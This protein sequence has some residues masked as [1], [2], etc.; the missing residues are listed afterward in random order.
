MNALDFFSQTQGTGSTIGP[1]YT[2]TRRCR[3]A[4]RSGL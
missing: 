2:A 3:T 4:Y 1:L